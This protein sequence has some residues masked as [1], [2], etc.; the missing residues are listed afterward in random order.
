MRTSPGNVKVIVGKIPQVFGKRMYC[1]HY[2]FAN[3]VLMNLESK[4]L[5]LLQNI[6]LTMDES[7]LDKLN[8]LMQTAS[9]RLEAGLESSIAAGLIDIEEGRTYAHKDVQLYIRKKYGL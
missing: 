7:L 3:F 6:L 2:V 5:Q 1:I 4:K 9:S 8:R